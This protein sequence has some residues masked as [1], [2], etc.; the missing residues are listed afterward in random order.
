M[1]QMH[2]FTEL[3]D[4]LHRQRLARTAQQRAA[5]HLLALR[6]ATRRAGPDSARVI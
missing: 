4:G 5:Q 3:A 2:Q 1:V 6:R